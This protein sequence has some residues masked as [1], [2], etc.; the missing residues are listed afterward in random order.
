[1]FSKILQSLGINYA[2]VIDSKVGS[3]IEGFGF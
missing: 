3:D 1:M 2:F